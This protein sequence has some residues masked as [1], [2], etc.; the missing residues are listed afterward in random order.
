MTPQR[1]AGRRGSSA[2]SIGNIFKAGRVFSRRNK[3][4][5]QQNELVNGTFSSTKEEPPSAPPIAT[6]AGRNLNRGTSS[7]APQEPSAK[8]E[9]FAWVD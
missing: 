5:D 9:N 8:D 3:M 7:A 1:S 2:K 6:I 4:K